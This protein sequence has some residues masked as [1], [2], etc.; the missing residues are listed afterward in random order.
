MATQILVWVLCILTVTIAIGAVVFAQISQQTIDEQYQQ[1][2]LAVASAVAQMP[3]ISSE[4]E[5]GDPHHDIRGFAERVRTATGASYVVITDRNGVRFSHPN[6]A[7]IGQRLE[8][9][10]VV[11]DGKTHVGIDPG[12]LGR[13]ANGKAPIF[14]A[15]RT[16]IGE[17]SV[18]I[19]E[20]AESADHARDIALIAGYSA[21]VLAI[22][23][24]GS[25]ILARRIKRITFGLEPASI[26]ALLQEREAMLHGIREGMIGFDEHGRITV[27]N[28]EARRLLNLEGPVL[29]HP[30]NEFMPEGRLRDL[31][32]GA[33]PAVDSSLLTDEALLV[34]NRMPVL[35]GGR[36]VGAV[37]TLRDR[38]EAE[39]LIRE[40]RAISGL[41]EAL[42]A[43]EHEYANRLFVISGLIELGEYEQV[44]G[45]LNQISH[46][47][48]SVNDELRARVAPPELAALL[49]AKI[50]IAGE[51]DVQLT[52]SED[53]HFEEADVDPQV[54]LTIVGNLVDNAFDAVMEQPGPREVVIR[55]S[56]NDDIRI[57]VHDNGPGIPAGHI[58]DVLVD[59]YSTKPPRGQARRGLGLALIN[60]IVRRLG[61]S[62]TIEPGPGGHFEVRLPHRSAGSHPRTLHDSE[63]IS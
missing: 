53:S 37:V 15:S 38:T 36:D 24:L 31:L 44:T 42:R 62:I 35:L 18:G 46:T 56:C 48:S 20:V 12:S 28:G 61:G 6:P 27:L 43:Q 1:R 57:E 29:G 54:L 51:H 9:P 45:Y 58:H 10:V 8:E 34:V 32:T 30:L 16:V 7:L 22:G 25:I 63:A 33:I 11:L 59:G 26:A 4:L 14:N 13:S 39:A 50:A 49:M 21:L 23:A 5:A 3:Q 55:L 40:V 60:R 17:V 41:S 52:L 2:S 19:L 47:P